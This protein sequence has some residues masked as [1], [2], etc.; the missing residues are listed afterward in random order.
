MR[1]FCRMLFLLV[2]LSMFTMA[3]YLST[4]LA[5]GFGNIDLIIHNAGADGGGDTYE[6]LTLSVS[7]LAVD[8]DDESDYVKAKAVSADGIEVTLRFALMHGEIHHEADGDWLFSPLFFS[9]RN[10]EAVGCDLFVDNGYMV[11]VCD[12]SMMIDTMGISHEF[13]NSVYF[14][15]DAVYKSYNPDV[16]EGS[17]SVYRSAGMS[18]GYSE[19]T[20][21]FSFSWPSDGG[22]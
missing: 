20:G 16:V 21:N 1:K 18:D 13:M 2:V 19:I 17:L 11:S 3:V 12:T 14:R 10:S 8:Y 5:E 7:I 4:A 9:I 15:L 6:Y 22:W